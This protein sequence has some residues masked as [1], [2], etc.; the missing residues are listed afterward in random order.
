MVSKFLR[1][2]LGVILAIA[3]GLCSILSS[4][5]NT[6]KGV[7]CPTAPIQSVAQIIFMKDCCGKL[8][9]RT[10][11]RKPREGEAGFLQCLCAEKKAADAHQ[12]TES[13]EASR[14]A[15]LDV[16]SPAIGINVYLELMLDRKEYSY[17]ESAVVGNLSEPPIPPP[18]FV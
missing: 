16:L 13:N 5:P 3:L 14:F 6:P 2:K 17:F 18:R 12:K 11:F 9:P 10:I 8:L 15:L 1:E 4:A 7:Q